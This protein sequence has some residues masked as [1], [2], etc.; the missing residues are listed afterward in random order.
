MSS[1][2]SE[3]HNRA[4]DS[5]GH[6][7]DRFR[8]NERLK[9]HL[10]EHVRLDQLGLRQRRDDLEDRFVCKHHR[11]V[12]YGVDIPGESKGLQPLYKVVL[13]LSVVL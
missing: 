10:I 4:P 6:H 5:G 11:P 9:M 13:K 1:A 7:T 2:R 12:K 8:G 3:I